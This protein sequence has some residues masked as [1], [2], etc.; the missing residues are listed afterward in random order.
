[1][2][3]VW[4]ARRKR[5][6]GL[7]REA[8]HAEEMLSTYADLVQLQERV[9]R[10]VL[11]RS[12]ATLAGA[13]EGGTPRFRLTRLPVGELVP[14]FGGFLAEAADLGTDAM[15]S[16]AGALST[17]PS[18]TRAALVEAALAARGSQDESAAFHVRAFLQ[19]VATALAE[20]SAG[21]GATEPPPTTLG[22]ARCPVCGGRPVVAAIQDIA[23]ALGS[24]ALV[25]GVCGSA[26]RSLRLA[27]PRCGETD[28][29]RLAVHTAESLAHV[30]IDECTSCSHYLKT[31]DLRRRGDVLP[32]VDDLASPELDLWAREHGL[33]RVGSNLFGL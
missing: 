1:M 30:R 28:P 4:V 25:C 31:F 20:H 11:V 18:A 15:R 32:L 23:G 5:A 7:I 24:R 17:A 12:W 6:I 19:A 33:A 9:A 2:E 26:W 13:D 10:R 3:S 16:D 14:L 27:C 29:L 21:A 8:P 22:F